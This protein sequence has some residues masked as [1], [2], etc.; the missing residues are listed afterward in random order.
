M[1]GALFSELQAMK[2]NMLYIR[3]K[4]KTIWNWEKGVFNFLINSLVLTP[5]REMLDISSVF[6]IH[7]GW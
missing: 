6:V 1:V 4:G 3:I 5:L 7:Q 2:L